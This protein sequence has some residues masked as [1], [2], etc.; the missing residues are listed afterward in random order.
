MQAFFEALHFFGWVYFVT[1]RISIKWVTGTKPNRLIWV[2]NF[3]IYMRLWGYCIYVYVVNLGCQVILVS[4]LLLRF[5]RFVVYQRREEFCY[6][7]CRSL[8]WSYVS[9]ALPAPIAFGK[10]AAWLTSFKKKRKCKH[11][12]KPCISFGRVFCSWRKIQLVLI[13]KRSM[14]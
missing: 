14:S 13:E 7:E 12:L 1:R 6:P 5:V 2:A 3:E 4:C 10:A 9:A 11:S 8:S